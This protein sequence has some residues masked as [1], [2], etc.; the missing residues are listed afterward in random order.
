MPKS[1]GPLSN[2]DEWGMGTWSKSHLN[3]TTGQKIKHM[4]KAKTHQ[5]EWRRMLKTLRIVH[6]ACTLKPVF[7]PCFVR[8]HFDRHKIC[9]VPTFSSSVFI[10]AVHLC[11]YRGLVHWLCCYQVGW[12]V[13]KHATALAETLFFTVPSTSFSGE[14]PLYLQR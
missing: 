6:S 8:W 13:G 11:L 9:I 5:H 4:I 10:H 12:P 14:I 3:M 2:G 1:V 7:T